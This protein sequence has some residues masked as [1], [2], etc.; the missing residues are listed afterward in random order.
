MKR[1]IKRE[2]M[3]QKEWLIKVCLTSKFRNGS[4]CVL[5]LEKHH[6]FYKL[7]DQRKKVG[8]LK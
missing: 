7:F 2:I 5:S 6:D 1:G 8:S 3:M 4:F